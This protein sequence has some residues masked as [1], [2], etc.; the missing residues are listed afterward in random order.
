MLKLW[1]NNSTDGPKTWFSAFPKQLKRSVYEFLK[2]FNLIF[3]CTTITVPGKQKARNA[4]VESRTICEIK[5]HVVTRLSESLRCF[6][7]FLLLFFFFSARYNTQSGGSCHGDSCKCT[8][9]TC[10]WEDFFFFFFKASQTLTSA[11]KCLSSLPAVHNGGRNWKSHRLLWGF[12][13]SFSCCK[14]NL[15]PPPTPRDWCHG[16]T[17]ARREQ[18]ALSRNGKKWQSSCSG[19]GN[20]TRASIATGDSQCHGSTITTGIISVHKPVKYYLEQRD[21]PGM[22]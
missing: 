20:L 5:I 11:N 17:T 19:G 16:L 4:R 10:T 22:P 2:R 7:S 21:L 9:L 18:A 1:T 13:I 15:P 3:S 12:D 14:W 6:L 8:L